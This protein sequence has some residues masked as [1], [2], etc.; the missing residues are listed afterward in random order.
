MYVNTLEGKIL[1][2]LQILSE[3]IK[4][5]LKY[6]IQD[7][8]SLIMYV[9]QFHNTLHLRNMVGFGFEYETHWQEQSFL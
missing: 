8:I 1:K 3:K 5:N 2:S 7:C 9:R 4:I 6:I